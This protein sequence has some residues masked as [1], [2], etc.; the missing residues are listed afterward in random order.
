M[1]KL[2]STRQ[3]ILILLISVLTLK[4]LYLPSLLANSVE[5]D[6][7]IFVFLMLLLDFLTLLVYLFIFNKN[8][9]LTLSEILEMMFGKV[10]CKIILFL[11][12]LF[13]LLKTFGLFQANFSYL[14]EN[15]YSSIKWHTFAFPFLIAIIF[16]I[17]FGVNSIARLCEI[18]CP[19]IIVGFLISLFIGVFKADYSNLLPILENGFSN[20]IQ[21]IVSF[22]FW[23]G[24]YLIFLFFL[25]EIKKDK[26]F[27]LKL[28]GILFI[29][30]LLITFF[31]ATSY[32][33]F[34]YNSVC[35]TN[36]ISD[37][38]QV[39]PSTSDIG[40][41]DWLLILI[42]DISLFLSICLSVYGAF[43]C[44]KKVFFKKFSILILSLLLLSILIPS[45]I[46]NFD[47]NT[48]INFVK[49]YASYFC[50]A[51]EFALPVLMLIFSFRIKKREIK[52]A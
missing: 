21:G 31:I 48:G 19:I 6:S 47:I 7:Y 38:L 5:R 23:F 30:V 20:E 41:F 10:I 17:N 35:H 13:F 29:T 11:L 16:I 50:L 42:W 4:V 18:F 40:S 27:N 3:I 12:M 49:Q 43:Y 9:D 51:V 28:L 15:L 25:G 33:L 14:S 46:I 32:A 8:E 1:K 2:V 34:N 24:D 37:M 44:F 39:L 26:K 45:I 22:S 36:T 52:N